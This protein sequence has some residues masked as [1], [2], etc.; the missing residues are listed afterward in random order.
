[1][2]YSA[3]VFD[4]AM[5]AQAAIVEKLYGRPIMASFHGTWSVASLISAGIGGFLAGHGV[6]VELHFLTVGTWRAGGGLLR[7]TRTN[8]GRTSN[9]WRTPLFQIAT[10]LPFRVGNAGL[11]CAAGR[12]GD[13]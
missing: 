6:S 9:R 8:C 12:R 4:V 2:V 13:W 10:A 11:L 7:P 5:N 1:M 3:A